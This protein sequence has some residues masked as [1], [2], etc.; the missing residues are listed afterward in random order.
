VVLSGALLDAAAAAATGS[1]PMPRTADD[2]R[3]RAPEPQ[4]RND[5]DRRSL[6][7]A[8]FIFGR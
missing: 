8:F 7:F 2:P 1:G 4:R 5:D 3:N 6:P